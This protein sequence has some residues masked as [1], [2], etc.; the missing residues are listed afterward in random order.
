MRYGEISWLDSLE[1][2]KVSDKQNTTSYLQYV[3]SPT[4]S[5]MV[6]RGDWVDSLVPTLME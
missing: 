3:S 1:L 4:N 5:G 2:V 6:N